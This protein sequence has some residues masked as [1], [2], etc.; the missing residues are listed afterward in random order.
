MN[1]WPGR[2]N[3]SRARDASAPHCA[4]GT[5]GSWSSAARR[6]RVTDSATRRG[7]RR[8][9]RSGAAEPRAAC[10]RAQPPGM[11]S[12]GRSGASREGCVA[13][14]GLLHGER[15][16]TDHRVESAG[17]AAWTGPG[18]AVGKPVNVAT[19]EC[20]DHSARRCSVPLRRRVFAVAR[21]ARLRRAVHP[22][23]ELDPNDG[24][25]A[26]SAK[27]ESQNQ[28]SGAGQ[29]RAARQGRAQRAAKRRPL[30]ARAAELYRAPF[31]RQADTI[32]TWLLNRAIGRC[33]SSVLRGRSLTSVAIRMMSSTLWMLRSVPFGK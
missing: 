14:A 31:E 16:R 11:Q 10:R 6:S 23:A 9:A 2:P 15:A 3:R 30:R 19:G 28:R 13:P 17:A 5:C 33:Q 27:L 20:R 22:P 18:A 26:R 7:H 29:S 21:H 32:A 4:R 25:F 1:G 8:H 24:Q 12:G